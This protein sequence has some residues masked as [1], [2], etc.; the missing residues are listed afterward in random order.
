MF[1][2]VLPEPFDLLLARARDGD[3]RAF[4]GLYRDLAPRVARYLRVQAPDFAEDAASDAWYEV[5]RAIGR[6]EGN[7]IAFRAWVFT[8][9]RHK[10]V[11]HARREW[12]TR[13]VELSDQPVQGHGDD[14]AECADLAEQ[15]RQAVALVR[16]L[17]PDQ[18]EVVML[19]VV[20]GLDNAEIAELLDKSSGAVRVLAH[21]GLRRLARTLQAAAPDGRSGADPESDGGAASAVQG[22]VTR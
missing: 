12:R 7:E 9:A 18:A 6:F 3:E 1:Q 14:A 15:T 5:A 13:R 11:D 16:T 17:P 4:E 22:G 2:G 10:V 19:R 8:I 20:A 21:R